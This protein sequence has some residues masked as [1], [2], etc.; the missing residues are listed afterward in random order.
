M[1]VNYKGNYN[2]KEKKDLKEKIIFMRNELEKLKKKNQSKGND[3]KWEK[4]LKDADTLINKID[5]YKD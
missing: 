1:I 2:K 5:T 3:P 4:V